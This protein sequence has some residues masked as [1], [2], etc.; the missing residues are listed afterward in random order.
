MKNLIVRHGNQRG[1]DIEGALPRSN[2]RL[3]IEAK[4]V[5]PSGNADIAMG[6]ALLQILRYYDHDVVCGLAVPYTDTYDKLMRSIMPGLCALGIHVFLVK[7]NEV[8][9]VPPARGFFPEKPES[10][11][12]RLDK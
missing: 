11:V 12:E 3:F 1:A 4:G 6:E 2:R 8:W 10:L 5:R 9:Y 7:P